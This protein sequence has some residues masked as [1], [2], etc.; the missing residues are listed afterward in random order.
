MLNPS[1]IYTQTPRYKQFRTQTQK[2]PPTPTHTHAQANTRTSK[3][4]LNHTHSGGFK[5]KN[6]EFD[7]FQCAVD[8]YGDQYDIMG[9]PDFMPVR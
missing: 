7:L 8:A 9:S 5:C 2:A 6:G 4:T 1:D 3:H